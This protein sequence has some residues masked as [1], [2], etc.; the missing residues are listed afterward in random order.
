MTSQEAHYG[1]LRPLDG[2]FTIPTAVA[3]FAGNPLE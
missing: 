3:F 2:Y 1:T